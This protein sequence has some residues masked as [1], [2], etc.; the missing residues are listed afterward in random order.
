MVRRKEGEEKS[1][2]GRG[3]DGGGQW[4]RNEERE[5]EKGRGWRKRWACL[6]ER[7]QAAVHHVSLHRDVFFYTLNDDTHQSQADSCI[8]PAA[9]MQRPAVWNLLTPPIAAYRRNQSATRP[10][11]RIYL[12]SQHT[13]L[14]FLSGKPRVNTIHFNRSS[15]HGFEKWHV[16]SF[17]L[18]MQFENLQ[19]I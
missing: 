1:I 9:N 8:K 13:S 19:R 5:R 18:N 11:P 16:G 10:P 3:M 14:L 2:K 7:Q 15:S 4:S 17:S 12:L 6:W